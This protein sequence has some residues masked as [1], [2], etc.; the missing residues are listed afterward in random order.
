MTAVND[1]EGKVAIVTGSASGV[2]EATVRLLA[3]RGAAV[4]LADVNAERG[5]RCNAVAPGLILSPIARRNM[6]P[7]D[8]EVSGRNQLISHQGVPEDIAEVV[9][10]LASDAARFEATGKGWP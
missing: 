4:V 1:F 6:S 3:R 5:V 10:F 9:A 2:G 7:E 8:L